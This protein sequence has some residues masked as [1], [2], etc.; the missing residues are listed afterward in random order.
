MESIK[1]K[2]YNFK[3]KN[4]E[5]F[6]RSEIDAL[7]KH[8]PNINMAKHILLAGTG[9]EMISRRDDILCKELFRKAQKKPPR[10]LFYTAC[11]HVMNIGCSF[12]QVMDRRALKLSGAMRNGQPSAAIVS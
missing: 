6:I 3:T 11:R 1:N 9:C 7:L 4:K 2:V 12:Q 5:G 10:K 8:Y